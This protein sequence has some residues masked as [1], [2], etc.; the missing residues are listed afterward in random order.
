MSQPAIQTSSHDVPDGLVAGTIT[1]TTEQGWSV[2]VGA[3]ALHARRAIGC[4]L[5]PVEG[6][7]VLVALL[8]DEAWVLSVLERD[9]AVTSRLSAPGDM[10]LVAREGKLRIH[11]KEGIDLGTPGPAR[12]TA[13]RVEVT[14]LTAKMLVRQLHALGERAISEFTKVEVVA[15]SVDT[16]ADRVRQRAKRVMRFVEGLDQ[17]RAGHVDTRAEGLVR[18][19]AADQVVTADG[20]V[21][22]DAKQVHIG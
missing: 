12:I 18:T 4:L 15:E 7:R 21:K 1:T 16:L 8:Q 14:A 3:R 6:D 5:E 9:G 11:S 13:G 20:L 19:H 2:D 10:E 22:V 17:L